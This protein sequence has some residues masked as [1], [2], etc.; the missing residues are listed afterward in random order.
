MP[1]ACV[2]SR[3]LSVPSSTSSSWTPLSISIP[4]RARE[5]RCRRPVAGQSRSVEGA[6]TYRMEERHAA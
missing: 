4:P 2:R 5:R 6:P 1:L 3:F